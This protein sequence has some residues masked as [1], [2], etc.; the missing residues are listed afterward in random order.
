[1]I[2]CYGI[3]TRDNKSIDEN[4]KSRIITQIVNIGYVE[5]SFVAH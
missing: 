2:L 5:I 4:S 1:V 3:S